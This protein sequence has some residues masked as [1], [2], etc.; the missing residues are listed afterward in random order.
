MKKGFTLIELLVVIAIIA[1]LS[2]LVIVRVNNSQAEARDVKRIQALDET[3]KA[4]EMYKIKFGKYPDNADY[5]SD[6]GCWGWWDAGNN[7]NGENDPF[8]QVL[9]DNGFM[10]KTPR[11]TGDI[12]DGW[13][14]QCT[15]RYAKYTGTCDCIGKTYAV[16]YAAL[17]TNY[18]KE[19]NTNETPQC[20]RSCWTEGTFKDYQIYLE[21]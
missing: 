6:V 19:S 7:I 15:Y 8:L 18:T 17:E 10:S 21:E 11:E 4:L 12:R 20:L 5:W 14:S 13:N 2:G 16:L 1:I 3:A 9:V